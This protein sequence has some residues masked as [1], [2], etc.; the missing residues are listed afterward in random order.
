MGWALGWGSHSIQEAQ[1]FYHEQ[2]SREGRT[3]TFNHTV[4][5][6]HSVQLN[7]EAGYLIQMNQKSGLA[8]L[9][10]NSLKVVNIEH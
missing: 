4:G 7:K 3:V 9:G 8:N 2:L 10:R 5:Q 1:C 6:I